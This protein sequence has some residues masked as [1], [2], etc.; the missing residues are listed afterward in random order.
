MTTALIIKPWALAKELGLSTADLLGWHEDGIL[1]EPI[2]F[3]NKVLGWSKA[4]IL[5]WLDS[6]QEEV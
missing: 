6:V 1:P 5:Q 4:T 3:G 2:K